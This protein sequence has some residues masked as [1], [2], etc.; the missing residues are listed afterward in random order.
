MNCKVRNV[1]YES[2]CVVCNGDKFEKKSKWESFKEMIG[3]YVGE[4]SRSIFER[5][6]EHWQDVKAGKVESNMLK[7]ASVQD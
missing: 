5:A 6:G 7:H 3:V 2:A 1:L 4:T